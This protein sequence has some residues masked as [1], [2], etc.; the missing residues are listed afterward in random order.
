[1]NLPKNLILDQMELGPMENFQYFIGDANTKEV[2]IVDP[3]WDVEEMCSA[4]KEKGWD[5][6][7]IEPSI[8]SAKVACKD[9]GL[10]VFNGILREYADTEKFDVITFNNVLEHSV[11]PWKEVELAYNLLKDNGLIYC[12]FPNGNL[13]T[14][15]YRL[16]AKF[17]LADNVMKFLVFHQ[18]PLTPRFIRRML[19]DLNLNSISFNNSPASEGDPSGLFSNPKFSK[20]IKNSMHAFAQTAKTASLKKFFIGISLEATATKEV[21]VKL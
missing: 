19:T 20:T 7:G 10:D 21:S 15:I 17:G 16:A 18:F 3:G 6:V 9:F 14:K 12:R 13:H 4:A 1:M 2:A 8:Q 11:E 5:C